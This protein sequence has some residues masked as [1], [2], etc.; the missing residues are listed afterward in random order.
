MEPSLTWTSLYQK[1]FQAES[2]F[3][4]YFT[5][6]SEF[7]G[8]SVIQPMRQLQHAFAS[9]IDKGD[10]LVFYG[11]ITNMNMLFPACDF[12]KE[13]TIMDVLDTNL[14]YAE[15][16][17]KHHPKAFNWTQCFKSI[18]VNEEERQKWI[19]NE[20][21]L[22]R[23]ITMKNFMKL[24]LS[25]SGPVAPKSFPQVDCLLCPYTLT[26]LCKDHASFIS[27]LKNMT[28]L[29]KVGGH[30]ILFV[31]IQCTYLYIADFK[32]P[33]LCI[34]DD[35]VKNVLSEQGFLIKEAQLKHRVNQT[36]ISVMDFSHIMFLVAS[37]VKDV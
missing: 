18:Q 34:N 16:W 21:K 19:T 24:D 12:F 25:E 32:L 1:Y 31:F 27:T 14:Q 22:R 9:V 10:T 35:F 20:E 30:L 23:T 6:D 3:A 37:K 29:L 7:T 28:S 15:N 33:I 2:C 8:D 26:F 5:A 4:T 36:K 17:L 11:F 13:I